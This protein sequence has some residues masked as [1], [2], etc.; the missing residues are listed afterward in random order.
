MSNFSRRRFLQGTGATA[1]TLGV[2]PSACT[3]APPRWRPNSEVRVA[4]VGIRSRGTAHIGGLNKL[5]NVR[6][7]ALVDAGS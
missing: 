1:L 5:E 6:V 4:C 2:A 7:V 3:S